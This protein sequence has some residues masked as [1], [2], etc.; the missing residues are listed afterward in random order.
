[1]PHYSSD[2]SAAWEVVEKLI[3]ESL[4]LELRWRDGWEVAQYDAIEKETFHLA[5]DVSASL[6][7]CLGALKYKNIKVE[8]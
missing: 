3:A 1:M 8:E 4:F 6:A 5:E 2:I 7:I